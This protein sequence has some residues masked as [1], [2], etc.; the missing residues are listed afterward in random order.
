MSKNKLNAKF[1]TIEGVDGAGKSTALNTIEEYLKSC[2][3]K[4]V[5]TAEP[6]GTEVGQELR[7]LLKAKTMDVTT[8]TMLLFAARAEHIETV[9]RPA[10]ERG[11]WVLC[12]RFTDSTIAYQHY[13]K[14][15]EL[16]KIKELVNLVQGDLNPGTTFILDVP[17]HVSR[18]R[19]AKRGE[20]TDKFEAEGDLFFQK[21]IDGYKSIA[22]KEPGR[23][24]LIDAQATPEIV[25]KDIKERIEHL[26][27]K[28]LQNNKKDDTSSL[29]P[30]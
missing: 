20:A 13:A 5:R 1:I 26:F 30:V 25:S 12:D 11:D 29:K 4:V 3:Q 6:G 2:G 10:L 22:K 17:L 28:H 27:I 14:G 23:C 21:V 24:H 9:I 15:I 8:E 16:G 7:K 19:I 18:S